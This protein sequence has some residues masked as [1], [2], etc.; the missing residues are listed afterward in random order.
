M[1]THA[2]QGQLRCANRLVALINHDTVAKAYFQGAGLDSLARN[3]VGR[4]NTNLHGTGHKAENRRR[5]V[6]EDGDANTAA[7]AGERR[8]TRSTAYFRARRRS[9]RRCSARHHCRAAHFSV[10]RQRRQKPR[11]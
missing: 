7:R 4:L 10:R 6:Q 9:A 11:R 1:T 5:L 2:Y 8:I 3:V